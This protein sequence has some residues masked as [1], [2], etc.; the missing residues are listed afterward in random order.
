MFVRLPELTL[1][2]NVQVSMQLEVSYA[3]R[4]EQYAFECLSR[5]PQLPRGATVHYSPIPYTFAYA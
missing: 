4:C 5:S 2:G 1:R 3:S